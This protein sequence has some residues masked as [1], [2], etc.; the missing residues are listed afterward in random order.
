MSAESP[1]A[2]DPRQVEKQRI[3]A[4]WLR[5]IKE[6]LTQNDDPTYFADAVRQAGIRVD[7]QGSFEIVE[8]HQI[9]K[10]IRVLLRRYPDISLRMFAK[11]ELTDLGVMGYAAINSDTVGDAMRIL[12]NYHEL[13][14]DRYYDRLEIEGSTVIVTPTPVMAHIQELKNIAEDSLAGNRRT[15]GLLLGP[16]ADFN[17]TSAHFD[18]PAPDY[19]STYEV[20]FECPLQFEA[21]RNELRFPAAWLERP[22][23]SANQTLADVCTAMCDRLIGAGSIDRDAP[24]MVRRLLLSRPGRRMYRLDEAANELNLSATQLRKRLYRAGTTYK[25]LV[26]ETRMALAQHYLQDT[27]LSVQEVAYLLDYSQAAP[28]SRAFKAHY[29]IPPEQSRQRQ[30]S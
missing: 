25:A 27:T 6:C 30:G 19:V 24:Q 11:A 10:V 28:F 4:N 13:T 14:S 5:R 1:I 8:Q 16:D 26:L 22:V 7:W 21:G 15:L 23:A 18:F 20:V 9:D 12:Y 3:A 2:N 29:G 17:K